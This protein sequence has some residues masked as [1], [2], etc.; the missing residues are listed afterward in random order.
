MREKMNTDVSSKLTDD[1]ITVN[2]TCKLDTA[3]YHNPLTMKTYIPN[4]QELTIT[5]NGKNLMSQQSA[6][7]GGKFVLY[8]AAPNGGTIEIGKNI[9]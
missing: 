5:Q 6:D 8:N 9:R 3:L 1:V 4:W 2:L 7:E